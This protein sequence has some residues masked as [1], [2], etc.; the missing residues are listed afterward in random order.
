MLFLT[1]I[2]NT[3]NL[4]GH[5]HFTIIMMWSARVILLAALLDV[6]AASVTHETTMSHLLECSQIGK[7]HL[8]CRCCA[9]STYRYAGSVYRLVG[10]NGAGSLR[11]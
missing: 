3:L 4:A 5:S 1:P 10:E 7:S 2:D 8:A 6:L 11:S 9:A